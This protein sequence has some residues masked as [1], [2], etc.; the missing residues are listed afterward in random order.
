MIKTLTK[1]IMSL[2]ITS[3]NI[4]TIFSISL[5]VVFGQSGYFSHR[6]VT[7]MKISKYN[8]YLALNCSFCL[9]LRN[10]NPLFGSTQFLGKILLIVIAN[11]DISHVYLFEK[12]ANTKISFFIFVFSLFC[13]N[14][15]KM[16]SYLN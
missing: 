2:F 16:Y 8:Y 12:I 15:S 3:T 7:E 5:H 14:T 9:V 10:N 11:T 6:E 1:I 13:V 4:R